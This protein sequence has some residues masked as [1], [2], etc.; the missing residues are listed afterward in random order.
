MVKGSTAGTHGRARGRGRGD[1]LLTPLSLPLPPQIPN[2]GK[3]KEHWVHDES[4][5]SLKSDPQVQLDAGRERIDHSKPET[6]AHTPALM[7]TLTLTSRQMPHL[8]PPPPTTRLALRRDKAEQGSPKAEE[9]VRA[10]G[11]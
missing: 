11:R 9:G 1:S 10:E 7:R 2:Q 5:D 6:G 8:R 4:L 3:E